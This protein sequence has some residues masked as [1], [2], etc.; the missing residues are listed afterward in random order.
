MMSTRILQ[1]CPV[2]LDALHFVPQRRAVKLDAGEVDTGPF[3]VGARKTHK[4][5]DN[6][7]SRRRTHK[8]KIP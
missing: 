1:V 5:T 8:L 6:F 7:L 2:G 3:E 4:D